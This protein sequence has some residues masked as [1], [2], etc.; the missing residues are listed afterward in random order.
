[1]IV[2]QEEFIIRPKVVHADILNSFKP[3]LHEV[4]PSLKNLSDE[5]LER[6]ISDP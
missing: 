2:E 3:K 1:M 5:D 4:I 6:L